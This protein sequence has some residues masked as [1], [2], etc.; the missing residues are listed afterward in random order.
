MDIKTALINEI[1][2]EAAN[3]RKMLE[4]VPDDKL[5]WKP[6]EKSRALMNITKHVATIYNWVPRIVSTSEVDI[7]KGVTPAPD[8]ATNQELLALHDN[9]VN[10]AVQHLETM[11]NDM[12]AQPWTF[13]SGDHVVF[14][15]PKAAVIRNMALNHLVHHRGQLS[16]YLRLMNVPVPGMYG[17]S[18]DE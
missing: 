15:L 7:A 18:A 17:P 16:V 4:R 10:E 6:H 8:F 9:S 11:S 13:R 3:T 1:K 14:T 12:L 5:S 2:H